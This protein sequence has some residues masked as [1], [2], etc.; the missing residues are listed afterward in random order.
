GLGRRRRRRRPTAGAAP[1]TR[2]A[3]ASGR[4]DPVDHLVEVGVEGGQPL[5]FLRLGQ[6]VVLDRLVEAVLLLLGQEGLELVARLAVVRRDLGQRLALQRRAEIARLRQ[7]EEGRQRRRVRHPG[8]GPRR[9]ARAARATGALA[10]SAPVPRA[11][12]AEA[13]DRA[14]PGAGVDPGVDL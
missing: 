10:G 4:E 2:T 6:P 3:L 11:A 1:P 12:A 7:A 13:A 5:I 14:D 8:G 9:A